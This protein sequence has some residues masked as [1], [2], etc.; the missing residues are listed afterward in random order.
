M[1]KG[2]FLGFGHVAERG[3]AP[4]WKGRPDVSIVAGTDPREDRRAAFLQTFP[5][6]RWHPTAE[7]LLTSERLD[8][9][10]ICT[11]PG[12]H[13]MLVR[14]ALARS[15]HVL[16]EK[17]LVVTPEELRGLPA[18]AAEKGRALCTVHNWRHAP[19]L[20]K[21]ARVVASGAL[22]EIRRVRWET[23]RDRP[24]ISAGEG[25]NWRLDPVQAGGGILIDHGWHAFYVVSSWLSSAPRTVAARL[26][27]RKHH[28]WPVEDTVDLFLV[29]AAATAE[30]FLTWA[31][32]ERANRVEIFGTQGVL[33][34]DGGSLKLLD[35]DGAKTAD[36]WSV[37]SVAEGSHHPDWFAGVVDAFF[38]EMA[39]EKW[40]GRNLAEATLCANVMALARE[41]S[42]QGGVPLAIER[43]RR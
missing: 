18:L 22:G 31:D 43:M 25:E 15:I 38:D 11:P 23:L 21:I 40:R 29:Y 7:D 4:G 36:E 3:H 2:A 12:S 13:A 42:R 24:A 14:Q 10:D 19:A 1:L 26:E 35:A 17:P 27:T 9:V 28:E 30:I 5:E 34:L 16:C 41:S 37:P 33:R 32:S 20:A 39:D 8:F 6:A